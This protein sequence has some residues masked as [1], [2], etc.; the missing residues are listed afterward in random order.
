[1]RAR[2]MQTEQRRAAHPSTALAW[3][4]ATFQGA[5][6]AAWLSAWWWWTV[7]GHASWRRLLICAAVTIAP[8]LLLTRFA[9]RHRRR[10]YRA[11]VAT[12]TVAQRQETL[13][14]VNT[15]MSPDD[16]DLRRAAITIV[17]SHLVEYARHRA[18]A[19]SGFAAF[20][21]VSTLAAIVDSRW[22][23]ACSALGAVALLSA[24]QSPRQ[25]TRR[26]A[27]LQSVRADRSHLASGTGTAALL[28]R[29]RGLHAGA[30][31]PD[32]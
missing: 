25:L 3:L 2:A 10:T 1:M 32:S 8:Y 19:V 22:Y 24:L 18:L 15:G 17:R 16:A 5:L 11:L 7:G 28:A 30:G 26:L 14:A 27:R 20:V 31:Y 6:F 21:A 9:T 23:L 13:R 12:M 4:W 29:R